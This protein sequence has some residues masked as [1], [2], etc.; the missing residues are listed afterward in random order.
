[1]LIGFLLSKAS[2]VGRTGINLFYK[3]YKFLKI[4]WQGA[5]VVLFIFLF[6]FFLQGFLEKRWE[7]NSKPV[8]V[9]AI[10]L[11]VAGLYFTYNDFRH[12]LTHRLL[13]E[14]FHLGGY[15]FWIGWILI[16]LFY[17]TRGKRNEAMIITETNAPVG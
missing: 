17:L 11:A 12:T 2:L 6:L 13:G 9:I 15:L 14:R 16:S 7:K 10:L 1:V 3:E 8:H 4:W 5:G